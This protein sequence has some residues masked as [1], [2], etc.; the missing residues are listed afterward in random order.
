MN[1]MFNERNMSPTGSKGAVVKMDEEPMIPIPDNGKPGE[2][3]CQVCGGE[4]RFVGGSS[5]DVECFECKSCKA[6]H[7]VRVEYSKGVAVNR[8]LESVY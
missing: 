2:D 5:Y 3:F 1:Q 4:T 6:F 7:N 8:I